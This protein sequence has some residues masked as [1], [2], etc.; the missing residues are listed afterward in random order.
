MMLVSAGFTADAGHWGLGVGWGL[1]S[2]VVALWGLMGT[3]D[4]LS[5]V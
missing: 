5:R 4:A 3:V 1:I 2:L